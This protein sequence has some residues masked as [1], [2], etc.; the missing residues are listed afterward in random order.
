MSSILK[1]L[2]KVG[3]EKRVVQHAAPDLRLDQGLAPVQSKPLLPLLTG[4]T[5]GAVIVGLLFLW[6]SKDAIPV[7]KVQPVSE[8]QPVAA[9]SEKVVASAA[10]ANH[11]VQDNR[12]ATS[13]KELTESSTVSVVT[14]QPEPVT[15]PEGAKSTASKSPVN[16]HKAAETLTVAS[17]PS[18]RIKAPPHSVDASAVLTEPTDLPEGVS[19]AVT[20][21]FYQED[22]VNSMAVVNDLPVM[23]GTHVDSAI[24]DEIRPDGVLFK[25]A[26]KDYFVT[27]P[28]P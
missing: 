20:E 24:V 9:T 1:A 13:L 19:L 4:I 27:V 7:A 8:S 18:P 28:K 11:P 5:L 26:D 15:M 12:S 16:K 22:H 21:I 23:I 6:P 14:M 2:R 25:I 10:L 3:E 17:V